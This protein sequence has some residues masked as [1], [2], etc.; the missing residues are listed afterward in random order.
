MPLDTL[1]STPLLATLISR[2][3]DDFDARL[4]GEGSKIR[5]S[6]L[7]VTS[8]VLAGVSYG[9]YGYAKWLS[10][11]LIYDTIDDLETMRAVAAQWG[12]TYDA[13]GIASGTLAFYGTESTVVPAGTV[14]ARSSGVEYTTDA[15]GTIAGGF[16]YIAVTASLI[17]TNANI[18]DYGESLELVSPVAGINSSVSVAAFGAPAGGTNPEELEHLKDRVLERIRDTPQGGAE[19]DYIQWAK[20][21]ATSALIDRVWVTSPSAG[22][23]DVKFVTEGTS[24]AIFPSAGDIALVAAAIENDDANGD[25]QNRPVTAQVT[26]A[27]PSPEAVTFSI[28]INPND[29]TT[30]QAVIDQLEAMFVREASPGATIK[31]SDILAAIAAAA[32]VNHW[33]LDAVHGGAG[34][35]DIVPTSSAHLPY[36]STITWA[37]A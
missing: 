36:V 14:V 8:R 15:S 13:G 7:Y 25:A 20:E 5:R 16:V 1:Y 17:G 21:A 24:A 30:Q 28:A 31:N 3:E 27:G 32:G 33:T 29:S 37:L 35:D 4:P 26:V 9:I 22:N 6:F 12:V 10:R 18:D 19:A 11:Q 2:I 23:V 34:T